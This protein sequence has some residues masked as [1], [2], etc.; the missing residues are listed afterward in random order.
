MA[1]TGKRNE[2][3]SR[4]GGRRKH[5]CCFINA[6]SFIS[7]DNQLSTTLMSALAVASRQVKTAA[8]GASPERERDSLGIS[9][10]S[11]TDYG[12]CALALA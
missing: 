3:T 6:P 9:G 11:L 1:G 12:A 7:D 5:L 8:R 4:A 2:V 10:C